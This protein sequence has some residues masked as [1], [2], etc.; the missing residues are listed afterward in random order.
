MGHRQLCLHPGRSSHSHT[1][2]HSVSS[3]LQKGL[4]QE[5][6]EDNSYLLQHDGKVQREIKRWPIP[7]GFL[8]H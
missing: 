2:I 1:P 7:E 3:D 6:S 5:L 4:G 8:I